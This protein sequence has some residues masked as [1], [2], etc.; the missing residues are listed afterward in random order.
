VIRDW[1]QIPMRVSRIAEWELARGCI[2]RNPATLPPF[3]KSTPTVYKL[4]SGKPQYLTLLKIARPKMEVVSGA[5]GAALG[6]NARPAIGISR[7]LMCVLDAFFRATHS[8]HLL[9]REAFSI[10]EEQS[11]RAG[12]R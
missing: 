5:M 9:T 12:L 2:W 3:M 10:T 4:S 7:S 11:S 8:M 6:S 1:P